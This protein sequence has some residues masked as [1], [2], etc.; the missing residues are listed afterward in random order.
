MKNMITATAKDRYALLRDLGTKLNLSFSS[1][2][3]IG[4]KLL[5]LDGLK[6]RILVLDKAAA[7]GH[8]QIA[9]DDVK[10]R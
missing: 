8:Y 7:N 2:L 6:R 3:A 5:A 1:Y 10:A 9:L 4:S